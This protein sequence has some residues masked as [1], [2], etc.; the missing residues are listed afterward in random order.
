MSGTL[1]LQ[2]ERWRREIRDPSVQEAP[3][4][5]PSFVND[6]GNAVAP[7]YGP[8]DLEA[9]GFDY[10][11]HLG[12]PGEFPY[13][14]GID[15]AMYRRALPVVSAYAG[16]GTP[17]DSNR[18]FRELI[19]LGVQSLSL[20]LDLPTQLGFDPD[21]LM[22]SG[23]VG[24]MG[25]AINTLRDLEIALEGIPLDT[26]SAVGSTANAIGP[27]VMAMFVALGEKQ[28]L[29]TS[30]YTVALQNDVLKEYVA[31]GTQIFP[32]EPALRFAVDAL[33]WCARHAPHWIPITACSN[34]IDVAGAGSTAATAFTL[35]NARCYLDEALRRGLTIDEV[36]PLMRLF[37]NEREDFFL[38]VANYRVTRRI[39]AHLLR[40]RYGARDPR[41]LQ[42]RIMGYAHGPR[43]TVQEPLNN[44]VRITMG[45]LTCYFGGLQDLRCASYD[46]AM[47]L[48]SDDAVKVAI[49]TQQILG[50][51]FGITSTVDPLGGSYYVEALANRMEHEIAS[52]MEH[53]DELGGA[54]GAMKRG[55]V[56]KTIAEGATRRQKAYERKERVSVGMNVFPLKA[57]PRHATFRIEQDVERQQIERLRQVKTERDAHKVREALAELEVCARD[58]RNVMPAL[59]DAVKAYASVGE[60][61]GVLKSVYGEYEPDRRF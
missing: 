3:E 15:P 5:R 52:I 6:A 60:I 13:T 16:F 18:R 10:A 33:E 36:A 61:C 57:E 8:G 25:V 34:H 27:I 20:A 28:G 22:A 38:A 53:I 31:R 55:Y 9:D 58:G 42:I 44:I 40:D 35:A 7:V 59:I 47:N 37:L 24:R 17:Q 26:L 50:H 4:R 12:F 46:E 41:S 48:P 23:E 45:A 14:R 1:R 43:E 56:Q 29:A 2:A 21:D 54:L 11:S 30:R 39:W 49:R 51:E 32:P 19:E